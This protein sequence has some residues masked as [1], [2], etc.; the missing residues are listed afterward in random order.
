MTI[1]D[2][3]GVFLASGTHHPGQRPRAVA[4]LGALVGHGAGL[5]VGLCPALIIAA[6]SF[7]AG[8]VLTLSTIHRTAGVWR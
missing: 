1:A 8:A 2:R 6:V 3:V 5:I 4:L 7:W